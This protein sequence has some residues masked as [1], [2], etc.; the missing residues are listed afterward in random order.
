M[1][2]EI[3]DDIKNRSMNEENTGVNSVCNITLASNE[4][5]F[6]WRRR[7]GLAHLTSESSLHSI[8]DKAPDENSM[9]KSM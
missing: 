6:N 3:A 9:R 7:T 2:K 8:G 1:L 4:S 5:K